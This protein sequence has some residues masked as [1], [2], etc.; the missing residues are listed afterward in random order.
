MAKVLFGKWA[1]NLWD[2][3]LNNQDGRGWITV[4]HKV[5]DKDV[6]ELVEACKK[7][8]CEYCIE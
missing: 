3:Y 5:H 1:T 7:D 2:V 8:G 4:L 6:D